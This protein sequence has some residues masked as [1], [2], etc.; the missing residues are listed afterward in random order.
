MFNI[1][2]KYTSAGC[3]RFLDSQANTIYI[4]SSKNI[5][6]RLFSQHFK[7]NGT[8]GHLPEICY[9]ST[10][11][12]EIM[13]TSDYAEALKAEQILIDRYIPRYNKRDKRK[14]LFNNTYKSDIKE[15]WK[16]YYTFREFDFN[17]I[18]RTRKQAIISAVMTYATF[19][20]LIGYMIW[21]TF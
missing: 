1:Q 6:R 19:I 7:R 11:K 2:S 21:K 8:F 20:A 15:K 13:K 12:I 17:K 3:Y 18:H 9:K 16:L 10:C 14:D 5:H 4:G